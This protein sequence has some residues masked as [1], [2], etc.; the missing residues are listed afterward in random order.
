[1]I[2]TTVTTTTGTTAKT[3]LTGSIWE[4]SI[5]AIAST[6]DKTAEC[7]DTTGIGA[8]VIQTIINKNDQH[9]VPSLK[10]DFLSKG[11]RCAS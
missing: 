3:M 7:K 10:M 6:G 8:T 5:G 11:I 9:S 4:N 2:G 1:M